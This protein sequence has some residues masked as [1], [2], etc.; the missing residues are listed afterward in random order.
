[1]AAQVSQ[2]KGSSTKLKLEAGMTLVSTLQGPKAKTSKAPVKLNDVEEWCKAERAR[3]VNTYNY[4][5]MLQELACHNF[6]TEEVCHNICY[7]YITLV[8]VLC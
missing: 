6:S 5:P 7:Q 3:F 2:Q 4:L 8:T 1:M